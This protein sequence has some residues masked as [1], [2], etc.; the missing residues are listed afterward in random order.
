MGF[1]GMGSYVPEKIMTNYDLEKLVDTSNEWIVERTGIRQ[2]HIAA[3]E[4]ATSDLAFIAAQ[5]ALDDANL[6]AED[7]DLI[8]VASESP[9]MKF[10]S[11]ACMLQ[12]R[13]GASHAAAF[14]LGAGCTGFAYACG[15]VSQT[16]A[17]GLYKHV[18]VVGAETLSRILDF[19]D[20]N[21][22]ILFGD[23]A[24]AAILGP[25]E[26]GYGILS[27]DL[28]ADGS[29][30]K[31]LNMP[32]GGSR[33]PASHETVDHHEHFIHMNGKEVFKFAV[34]VLGRSVMKALDKIGMTKN[35][36]DLLVPHQAN[37][38]IIDSAAKRLDLPLNKVM[39]NVDQYA[40]TS[41]ASIPIALCDARDQGRLKRDEIVVLVGFGAGL[42]Y[43]SLVIK[44]QKTEEAKKMSKIAFMFPG[45]GSQKVGMMK[46]LYDN[47]S[48][49]KDVFKEADEALGFSMTDL[50]FKGPEE[51]LR[52]T[53]NTQPA[54]LTCSV[55]A[56]K[57]LEENEIVPSVVAGHSLGEYSALVCAGAMSFADAVRTVRKRGQF[58]QEA[59]PV[60]EGAMA[61][62]IGLDTDKIKEI[63]AE[64]ANMTNQCVQA[65]NFNCPGQIVIAGATE[66]V[67][68]AC[69]RLKEAG[70]KRAILLPVSAP[71]HSTLMQPAADRLKEVLDSVEIVDA[72][73]PVVANVN[74]KPE[75][76]ADEIRSQLVLQ[77]ASPV[78]WEDS[79]R[80]MMN[81]G[82]DTFVE[83]GPGKVLCG[84]IKKVDRSYA[85]LNVEDMESLEKSLAYL[86]EVR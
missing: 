84:F 73:I 83:V 80:R 53:Y 52:L 27:V 72:K 10:P 48:V 59:V 70:A 14:D 19:T 9:D 64:T 76:K 57:V 58:M 5:R 2:R 44:W 35:D 6:K 63:C 66:A 47:Y 55:A 50:C 40:N 71:F 4:Q 49:V 82:V 29:G 61:A 43:G 36:I 65:V 39:V 42:T 23:G 26:D 46:D 74:A 60:G 33:H 15:I 17:S 37:V 30:G 16:I 34:R 38:R 1:L 25:V 51:Q 85:P 68:K 31:Y 54:I 56:M 41:A 13:L 22:C 21:T 32:G 8:V 79:V 62:I 7:L 67:H 45:Q 28:G 77:A 24:G 11:V 86:K 78:L 3:P 75:T 69:D 81:D 20:R 18:L 12:D